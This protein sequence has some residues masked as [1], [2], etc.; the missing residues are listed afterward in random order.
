ML[1][2]GSP[3]KLEDVV[4][5]VVVAVVAAGASSSGDMV[6]KAVPYVSEA[7]CWFLGS[8]LW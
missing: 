6:L 1:L 5:V 4:V 8:V 3:R 2:L 7:P